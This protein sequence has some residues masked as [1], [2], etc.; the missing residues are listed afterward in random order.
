M[1]G[2]RIQRGS[3]FA[4]FGLNSDHPYQNDKN[5][6]ALLKKPI[7]VRSDTFDLRYRDIAIVEEGNAGTV[8]GDVEFWDFVVIEGTNDGL[9]WIPVADGY[10]AGRANAWR[11]AFPNGSAIGENIMI[12]QSIS[13]LDEF[14]AGDTLLL[15]FRLF[16]DANINGFGWVVDD[17][18]IQTS[19]PE[20]ALLSI[21]DFQE[22]NFDFSVYPNPVNANASF[23]YVLDQPG[24]VRIAIYDL[25]GKVI[26]MYD[27]TNQPEGPGEFKPGALS[28]RAG[29]YVAEINASGGTQRIRIA[30]N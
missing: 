23:T 6:I 12:E 3:S 29:V 22:S 15:R 27:L 9:N 11:N 19:E 2:F 10:D 26:G 16:A 17:L 5:H 13:L 1:D 7:I 14:N 24:D 4:S 18:L 20:D 21:G 25:T 30:A 28:L 8:F